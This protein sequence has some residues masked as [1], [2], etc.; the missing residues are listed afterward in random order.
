MGEIIVTMQMSLDGIVSDPDR[1]MTLE[2]FVANRYILRQFH[3]Q[4][5]GTLPFELK[6]GF[7]HIG[8]GQCPVD[9]SH[10]VGQENFIAESFL[11]KGFTT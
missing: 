6:N 5:G 7:H 10:N 2:K 1:W 4:I 8:N 3:L 11:V 9:D